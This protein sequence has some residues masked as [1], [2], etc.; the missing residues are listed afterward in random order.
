MLISL[1]IEIIRWVTTPDNRGMGSN[2][3][4]F[5]WLVKRLLHTLASHFENG[6]AAPG[7]VCFRQ[8]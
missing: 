8:D 3:K 2:A 5:V 4:A 1:I 6:I 7:I